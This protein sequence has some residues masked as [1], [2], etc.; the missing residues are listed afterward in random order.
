MQGV[1]RAAARDDA[2]DTADGAGYFVA[3][4]F[5][6]GAV[7]GGGNVYDAVEGKGAAMADH[8]AVGFEEYL[9]GRQALGD[10]DGR[11][12]AVHLEGAALHDVEPVVVFAGEV[13]GELDVDGVFIRGLEGGQDGAEVLREEESR[14]TR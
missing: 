8:G 4:G 7:G 1:S 13:R 9:L 11:S 6:R 14:S 3:Q 2:V 10:F 12:A 5:G